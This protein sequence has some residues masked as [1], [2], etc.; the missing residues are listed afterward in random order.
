MDTMSSHHAACLEC[1]VSG[2]YRMVYTESMLYQTRQE[3]YCYEK[4]GIGTHRKYSVHADLYDH[5]KI[6]ARNMLS[7]RLFYQASPYL[8]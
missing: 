2:D 4:T 1:R 6:F 7:S 3:L 5:N 8:V